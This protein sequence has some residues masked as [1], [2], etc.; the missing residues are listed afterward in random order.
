[1]VWPEEI[2]GKGDG[3][4]GIQVAGGRRAQRAGAG[5]GGVA[6][7]GGL[8]FHRAEVHMR[9]GEARETALVGG[10]T[11]D[12]GVI[13]RVNHRRAGQRQ[14]GLRQAA[15]VAQRGKHR[16]AVGERLFKLSERTTA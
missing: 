16:V 15:I 3:G 11:G 6:H 4:A 5:I 1:M 14:H 12:G 10:K 13:A 2:G 8:K 7:D 9:A